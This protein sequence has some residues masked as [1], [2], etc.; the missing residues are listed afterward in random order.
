MR[1]PPHIMD[2]F[3]SKNAQ[4]LIWQDG[5]N[6]CICVHVRPGSSKDSIHTDSTSSIEI[7]IKAK[8]EAGKA[9]AKLITFLSR[10]LSI[11]ES[12]F[13]IR[14][15]HTSRKKVIVIKATD[16]TLVK[17]GLGLV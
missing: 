7:H 4:P 3:M 14:Q 13:S 12:A 9:N 17:H 1:K 16:V 11:P 8:A 6:T 5:P 2:L 10:L 15:G